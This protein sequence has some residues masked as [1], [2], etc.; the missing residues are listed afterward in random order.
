MHIVS[1]R[2]SERKRSLGRCNCIWEIILKR[3]LRKENG[4]VWTVFVWLRT[5]SSDRLL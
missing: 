4:M 3:I 5:G 1:I 2:E